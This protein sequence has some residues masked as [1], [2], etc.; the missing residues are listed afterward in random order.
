MLIQAASSLGFISSLH[1]PHLLAAKS[2]HL[3]RDFV[4]SGTQTLVLLLVGQAH[5]SADPSSPF[6][7]VFGERVLTELKVHLFAY[8]VWAGSLRDPIVSASPVLVL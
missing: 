7:L 1:L 2:P 5:F 6:Q 8:S 4:S 3:S